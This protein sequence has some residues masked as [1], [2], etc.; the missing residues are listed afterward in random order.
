M[1][2]DTKKIV[3]IGGVIVGLA[4]TYLVYQKIKGKVGGTKLK[5]GYLMNGYTHI[6]G[7]DRALASK[8]KE[9]TKITIK[10]TDFDGEYEVTQV[11]TD[12]NGNV[13]AFKTNPPI[14]SSSEKN[15][16]YED[17]GVIIIRNT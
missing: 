14:T 15:R 12:A 7:N 1:Q 2:E 4:I 11:W 13:G 8:I 17:K 3:M 6:S 10:K 16:A 9:G 5:M